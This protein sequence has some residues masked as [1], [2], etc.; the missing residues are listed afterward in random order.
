M[1]CLN[2]ETLAALARGVIPRGELGRIREHLPECPRCL[3]AIAHRA[4]SRP[5]APASLE[6]TTATPPVAPAPRPSGRRRWVA[7]VGAGLAVALAALWAAP[8]GPV[9]LSRAESALARLASGAREA[10]TGAEARRL[11]S[12]LR[13]FVESRAVESPAVE[14][15]RPGPAEGAAP[16]P[17]ERAP[18]PGWREGSAA[19]ER[20]AEA[21]RLVERSNAAAAPRHAAQGP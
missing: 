14:T 3:D 19:S 2:D 4:R 8:D 15:T 9:V 20:I 18:S 21:S 17:A 5:G 7:V 6:A 16:N 12:K 10:A 13:H 11:W 1:T